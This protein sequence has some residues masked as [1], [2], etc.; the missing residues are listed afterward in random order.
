LKV[1]ASLLSDKDHSVKIAEES[2]KKKYL[3]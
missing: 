1:Y 3:R 2:F